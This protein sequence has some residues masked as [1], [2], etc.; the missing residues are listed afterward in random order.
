[1][2]LL[3]AGVAHSTSLLHTALMGGLD[4]GSNEIGL[5]TDL[6]LQ[7]IRTDLFWSKV[8]DLPGS[9]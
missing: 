3:T 7:D 9:E 5:A 2:S 1:M 4:G 8:F 6:C